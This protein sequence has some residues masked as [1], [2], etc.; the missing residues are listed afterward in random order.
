MGSCDV[1]G[2][3]VRCVEA[4]DVRWASFTCGLTWASQAVATHYR[5]ESAAAAV[6]VDRS[7]N[8]GLLVAGTCHGTLQMLRFPCLSGAPL[9]VVGGHAGAELSLDARPSCYARR[10]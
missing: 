3:Q 6:P 5:R 2:P 4:V 10:C 8:G 9:T 1:D 7:R